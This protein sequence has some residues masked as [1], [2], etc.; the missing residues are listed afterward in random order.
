M[1]LRP[2]EGI[3]IAVDL[4]EMKIS[5]YTDRF[6]VPMPK[7]EGTEYRASMVTPPFGPRL[8][9][10]PASQPG[11]TGLKID[12]NTVRWANWRFHLGFDVRAGA[13]IFLASIY[14]SEKRK[15]RQVMY[16]GFISE[17]FI[18]Y[19]D[20]TEEWYQLT[21]FDC[22]E[23]GCGLLAVSLEPLNDC[24]A[25]AV[26]FDGYYAG[27]DVKPVKVEDAMCIF[28]RH[29]GDITWRHT[30][31]EI[32]NVEIREVRPEVSLVVRMFTTAG[33]YDYVFDWEFKP[34]GS[35][36]LGVG[37]TGVLEVKAVPHR[38]NKRASL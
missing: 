37:L 32:P 18:P 6:V 9:G 20:T 12:G 24:P 17:L 22:G 3:S 1:Y 21:Y 38:P 25:N 11:K 35:I 5:Q 34:S 27:Q 28:E 29:P 13:V 33:N 19:Q 7:A 4:E 15:Y 2:I 8:N 16:R 36:K 30:E 10:A 26:F 31:A 23:F 14:D